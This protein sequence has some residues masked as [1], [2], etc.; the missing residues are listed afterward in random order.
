MFKLKP[1]Y[2][3]IALQVGGSHYPGVGGELLE[4]FG[5]EVARQCAELMESQHDWVSNVAASKA[6]RAKFGVDDDV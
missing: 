2:H 3:D 4:K 1:I 5:K 6:I